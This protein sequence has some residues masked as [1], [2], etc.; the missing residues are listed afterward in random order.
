MH[1]YIT[2]VPFCMEIYF[3]FV[4]FKKIYIF[5]RFSCKIY[6]KRPIKQIFNSIETIFKNDESPHR[7]AK[8]ILT[9]KPISDEVD[10]RLNYVEA[11]IKYRLKN[12]T[13]ISRI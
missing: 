13:N 1:S 3:Y 12:A 11:R 7:D 8:S 4:K 5:A 6:S 9:E 2:F 10:S